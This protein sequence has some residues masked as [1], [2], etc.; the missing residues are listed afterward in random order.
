MT[1]KL[2]LLIVLTGGLMTAGC[3]KPQKGGP[4]KETFPVTG[5]VLV[6]GSPQEGISVYCN[7]QPGSSVTYQLT[8][9]TDSEGRFAI[10]TYVSGDGVPAGTYKLTFAMEDGRS[11]K[12]QGAYADAEASEWIVDTSTG[13][14][15][16]LGVIKLTTPQ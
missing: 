14:E 11:D 13:T 3:S 10:S 6:D 5:Q 16:D 4:R 2:T 8:D 7:P 12:L 9:K 1:G 15:F